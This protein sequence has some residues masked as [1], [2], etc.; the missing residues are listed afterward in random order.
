MPSELASNATGEEKRPAMSDAR[1]HDADAS[2]ADL[3]ALISGI[4]DYAIFLLDTQGRVRTWNKGAERIKGYASAEIIGK[5]FSLFYTP[6]DRE[7]GVPERALRT[8]RENGKFEAEAWRVRKDGT[9]F[10]ANVL[11]DAL[12]APDGELLGFAKVTRDMTE[13][14]AME[15][16]LAQSQKMEAIGQLTGGVA[17]DFNN[18]LTIIIGNLDV[19]AGEADASRR[20]RARERAMRGAQRA[21]KLTQQLLAFSRRQS[22]NPKHCDVNKLVT[23]TIELIRPVLGEQ[24][25][26]QTVLAP[27]SWLAEIDPHQFES[28]LLNLALNA[29][30]AMP[31]GGTLKI[32]TSNEEVD[33]RRASAIDEIADGQYV[34]IKVSDTGIGMEKDVLTHAFEPF[35]TTKPLGEG[36]G[37]GLSQVYGFVKQSGGHVR[38]DTEL[39]KGTTVTMYF[40]RAVSPRPQS[41]PDVSQSAPTGTETI[42]VVEDDPDVSQYTVDAL[43]DLGFRV[44]EAHDGA[45]ALRSLADNAQIDLLFTDVGL[46]GLNGRQ[47]AEQAKMLRPRLPVLFT[48]GYAREAIVHHGRLDPG[49][50]VLTKPYTR[51]QLAKAVRAILDSTRAV[52]NG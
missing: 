18:I 34:A 23:G 28:A 35:Y 24:V 40:P 26:V 2:H 17:H 14:K 49:I 6:E 25:V 29:R 44:L 31:H 42:L 15:E 51:V 20:E 10:Y 4:A 33:T 47:L 30:D 32:E 22:L 38:L 1:D 48:T 52:P 46:P 43:R 13:R 50:E 41:D 37:L 9:R 36:T 11:I 16:K 5:S 27:G 39:G 19:M 7:A 21:A 8:A 12:R 3:D 45:S